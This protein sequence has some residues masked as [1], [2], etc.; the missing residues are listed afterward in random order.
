MA[1][2]TRLSARQGRKFGFTLGF[3]FL[4]LGSLSFWRGHDVVPFLLLLP[5]A[6][7]VAAGLLAP[8]HLG[9]VERRWMAFGH[10]LSR[11]TSP[12]ILGIIYFGVLTPVGIIMRMLGKNPLTEHHKPGTTWTVRKKSQ[13]DLKRQF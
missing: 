13:S 1:V 9:P 4:L 7:L 11:F 10:Q 3:A 6:F 2:S 8:T 12:I 5:G